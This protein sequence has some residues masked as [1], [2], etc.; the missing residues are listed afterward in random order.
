MAFPVGSSRPDL[1]SRRDEELPGNQTVNVKAAPSL[2][3][4][5]GQIP[6]N[7]LVKYPLK[8]KTIGSDFIGKKVL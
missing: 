3:F 7:R 2:A 6:P 8:P 4:R 1:H 5:I